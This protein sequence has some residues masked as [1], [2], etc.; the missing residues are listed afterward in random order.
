MKQ[1]TLLLVLVLSGLFT[2]AQVIYGVNNYTQYHVGTLPII[3]SVPHGGL[4]APSDI[5][6]RTCGSPTLVTDGNTIELARQMDSALYYLTGC[7]PHLIICNLKRTKIDCNRNLADGACGDP[8]AII[9]WTEF[10]DFI[11][12]AQLLAQNQYP[13]KPLYIDLHGHGHTIPRLELGY[14]LWSSLLNSTDSVLNL[15]STIAH[16]SI[17]KLV[18]TNIN[19]YSHAELVRGEH[20]L[21]TLFADAGF[22][23][24]PSMYM[25]G[26]DTAAFF[27]GGYNTINNT[28][29]TSGNPINGLQ[30]ECHAAVRNTYSSRKTFAD[31][32]AS[33][34]IQYLLLHHDLNLM[35]DCGIT[36]SSDDYHDHH[37][38][39]FE[40]FPNP[41]T[42]LVQLKTEKIN[43]N[44]HVIVL[45]AVGEKVFQANNQ[46]QFSVSSFTKGVYLV[47]VTNDQH[48]TAKR[49]LVVW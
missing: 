43:G 15:P 29:V 19:G 9:A 20:A 46:N 14:N 42:N 8:Q 18:A 21:G 23:S 41:A 47:K 39:S 27:S 31:S 44:Y 5:P 45:N 16:S 11:D 3:I 4:V 28:C 26:P 38:I 2:S 30:I 35:V 34:L 36:T 1:C 10:Q 7:H 25:P 12:T 49:L 32:T 40:L 33:V 6:D 24:V 48:Q 13:G 37:T 22:P 17:N